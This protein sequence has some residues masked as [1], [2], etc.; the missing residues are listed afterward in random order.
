M[1]KKYYFRINLKL[2]VIYCMLFMSSCDNTTPEKNSTLETDTV[3][4]NSLDH[5][6]SASK[7]VKEFYKKQR[8]KNTEYFT[9]T[10]NKGFTYKGKGGTVLVFP[11]GVFDCKAQDFVKLEVCEFSDLATIVKSNLS[12]LSNGKL[13]ET[14]GMVYCKAYSNNKEVE[15]KKGRSFKCM[16]NKPKSNGFKLFEGEEVDGDIN[17]KN[18]VNEVAVKNNPV[19]K[20]KIAKAEN[21]KKEALTICTY[22]TPNDIADIENSLK[23]Q[24]DP[25]AHIISYFIDNYD[26]AFN[27]LVP[28]APNESIMLNF[29]LTKSGRL[30]FVD[31][32]DPVNPRIKNKLIGYF[33]KMPLVNGYTN[34]ETGE[35]EDLPLYMAVCPNKLLNERLEN[36]NSNID[37]VNE[38]I[39]EKERQE[40]ERQFRIEKNQAFSDKINE[41]TNISFNASKMGWINCDRFIND[42]RQRVSLDFVDLYQYTSYNVQIV[43]TKINS[44][45]ALRRDVAANDIPI[46]EPVKIIFVGMKE[47]EVFFF[48]KA[49]TTAEVNKI[50]FTDAAK[51]KESELNSYIE[52]SLNG[53]L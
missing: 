9:F 50:P 40:K 17:W 10:N 11:P 44:I 49:I 13:L 21:T 51:I 26:I 7:N 37:K 45:Y 42:N 36:D 35:K 8:L 16:F 12:T 18:P 20:I 46:N 31:S 32:G 5:N 23:F 30:T 28:F 52:K 41:A 33:E 34:P 48:S 29:I 6:A 47:T 2:V 39:A 15:L 24:A 53:S 4:V 43:F 14:N 3:V 22:G 25:L 19:Q 38:L 27:D 1:D